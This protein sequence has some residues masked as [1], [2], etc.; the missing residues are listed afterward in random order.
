MDSSIARRSVL[1]GA[2]LGAVSTGLTAT[3][4]TAPVH[5]RPHGTAGKAGIAYV[6]SRTTA[7]RDAAGEGITV[8]QVPC[9]GSPWSL[10]QTVTADDG[11]G[12][13]GIPANPTFLI[14]STDGTRAYCTHGDL[15]LVSSFT[16]DADTGK[17]THH[18]TVSTGHSN[19]VHLSL[20]PDGR[21]LVVA[22]F[23][24]PGDLCCIAVEDNG[25]LGDVSSRLTLPG[26]PGRTKELQEGPNPH[27]VPWDPTGRWI[28]V[29]DRGL[30]VVHVVA[31]DQESGTLS[32]HDQAKF[33]P[34]DGP[35]H[36]DFHPTL[37]LAYVINE[38]N[39][40]VTTCDWDADHG[41]LKPVQALRTVPPTDLR[42]MTGAEIPV[43]ASG[44]RVYAS[45]R[46]GTGGRSTAGPGDDSLA[47]LTLDNAGIPIPDDSQVYS[48]RG[49]RPRFIG[50]D[51][52][53]AN[54]YAANELSNSIVGFSLNPQGKVTR[55]Q[56]E[57]ATTG[58]PVC[59]TFR[60]L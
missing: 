35:R 41:L 53:C 9:D 28:L 25:G 55:K 8:W 51:P 36:I 3:V 21:W 16:V 45:N 14:L 5:A 1:T 23:A 32:L 49:Q 18:N 29:P 42:N 24:V 46:S 13:V 44:K 56:G 43:A 39:A 59:I 40:A 30:D 10:L 6:G 4:V 50:I 12:R 47:V 38:I 57:V 52:A 2:V 15:Q 22:N 31:L 60:Q 37:P 17:L 20:S 27:H 19:P 7:A 11:A 54:L 26:E 48:T 33:R 34:G 58:S